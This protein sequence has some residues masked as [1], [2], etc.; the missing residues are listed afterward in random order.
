[1]LWLLLL[2]MSLLAIFAVQSACMLGAD[3]LW[4]Q[5]LVRGQKGVEVKTNI[6]GY[7][8][9]SPRRDVVPKTL[10]PSIAQID[11]RRG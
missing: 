6:R 3:L 10:L 5:V 4:T 7:I 8:P 2:N 1:M 11:L 9:K